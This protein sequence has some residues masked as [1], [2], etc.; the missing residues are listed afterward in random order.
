MRKISLNSGRPSQRTPRLTQIQQQQ[1]P[2]ERNKRQTLLNSI[3]EVKTTIEL[4][5]PSLS[6]TQTSINSISQTILD[7]TAHPPTN[8]LNKA[9]SYSTAVQ[10]NLQTPA[11][12]SAALA[13][14]AIKE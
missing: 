12:V 7:S 9:Q 6:T 11:P 4:L 13:R 3:K 1:Q 10:Q 14:A 5:T 8:Q 2:H